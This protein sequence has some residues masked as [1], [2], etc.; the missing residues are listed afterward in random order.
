MDQSVQDCSRDR[1]I[2]HEI[3][4]FIK[5][6]V[7]GHD[8]G[9]LFRHLGYESEKQVCFLRI[10]RHKPTSSIVI[11][12]AFRIYFILRLLFVSTCSVFRS[13]TKLSSVVKTA[14]YPASRALCVCRSDC[15]SCTK[16]LPTLAGDCPRALPGRK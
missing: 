8:N 7:G 10:Q 4:P 2:T 9:C 3:D 16:Y 15:H 5:A 11:R 13:L 14:A 1:C 6:F 12:A